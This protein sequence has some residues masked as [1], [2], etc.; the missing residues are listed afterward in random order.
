MVFWHKLPTV[1]VLPFKNGQAYREKLA[2]YAGV[3]DAQVLPGPENV[4][5]GV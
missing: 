5:I 3:G 1:D 4:Y 2:K